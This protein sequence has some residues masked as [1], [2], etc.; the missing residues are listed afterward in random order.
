MSFYRKQLYESTDKGENSEGRHRF[1][2]GCKKL[3]NLTESWP[4]WLFAANTQFTIPNILKATT[5]QK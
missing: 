4:T 2:C 5:G 1:M 3:I